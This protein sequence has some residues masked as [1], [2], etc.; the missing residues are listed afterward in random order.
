[1]TPAAQAMTQLASF[2]ASMHMISCALPV[3]EQ[4]TEP[5]IICH[6]DG[7][8]LDGFQHGTCH[9]KS[10]HVERYAA[11]IWQVL[12]FFNAG[13]LPRGGS[14]WVLKHESLAFRHLNPNGPHTVL[15]P[16]D[17]LL[18][19]AVPHSLAHPMLVPHSLQRAEHCAWR[20]Q[21]QKCHCNSLQD[22]A[23]QICQFRKVKIP[24]CQDVE[25]QKTESHD[26]QSATPCCPCCQHPWRTVKFETQS[27]VCGCFACS[28]A[29]PLADLF[30]RRHFCLSCQ[31]SSR[32][33]RIFHVDI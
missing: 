17:C 6:D 21:V 27:Q 11:D 23:T 7:P 29:Q 30:W 20:A 13:K 1:M 16:V 18:P 22:L 26:T 5:R 9:A 2:Y 25:G 3:F 4:A 31:S 19:P 24:S 28:P 10:T 32:A 8:L 12:D 14:C 33:R 15:D